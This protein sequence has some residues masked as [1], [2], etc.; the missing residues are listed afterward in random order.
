MFETTKAE[1]NSD[2][3]R[4]GGL[5]LMIAL[6][7]ILTALGFEHLGGYLPCP[8]CLQQRYAYYAAIPLLFIAMALAA[9]RPRVAA[10]VFLA[11]SLAFLANT[12]LGVFHSGV[13][14]G[15]WPGPETC[16]A[17]QVLPTSA[18][19]LLR[20]LAE[21]RA[22]RCDEAEWRL[23]GLSFAGW[24]AVVSLLLSTLSLQAAFA[25]TARE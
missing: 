22:I 25:I 6:G 11:V 19:D 23:F 17:Q 7:V 5:A 10:L 9:E 12:G 1:A 16:D 3:Y 13:E 21:T 2:A 24:N 8:L 20:G 14:W 4:L 15:F 18:E